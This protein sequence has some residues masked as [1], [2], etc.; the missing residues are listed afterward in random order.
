M[1]AIILVNYNG[2]DDTIACLQSLM[3]L[4]DCGETVEKIVV[5][6][7]SSDDSVKRLLPLQSSLQ[8]VLLESTENRGFSA[9][10]NIGI[11]YAKDKNAKFFLLLNN[12]TVVEP[13]KFCIIQIR[14]KY[15]MQEER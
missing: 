12:D 2:A 5:D 3:E 4:S 8:F 11:K 9:G 13:R 7:K 1:I 15:G 14:Q 10:N 6:N